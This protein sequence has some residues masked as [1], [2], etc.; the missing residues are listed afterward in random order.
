MC[1]IKLYYSSMS[2]SIPSGMRG[3][4]QFYTVDGKLVKFIWPQPHRSP[5]LFTFMNEIK[6]LRF[7]DHVEELLDVIEDDT[8]HALG[9]AVSSIPGQPMAFL[10]NRRYLGTNKKPLSQLLQIL[11]SLCDIVADLHSNDIFIGNL[12]ERLLSFTEDCKVYIV[13]PDE[14]LWM[15]LP[16]AYPS[17]VYCPDASMS[18]RHRDAYALAVLTSRVLFDLHPIIHGVVEGNPS[19]RDRYLSGVPFLGEGATSMPKPSRPLS[20]VPKVLIDTLRRACSPHTPLEDLKDFPR[21]LG[22]VL[23][24]TLD[25]LTHCPI[26]GDDYFRP[27]GST[28]GCPMC[29]EE[30]H[31][32][33]IPMGMDPLPY[34][35]EFSGNE[36]DV[37][38]DLDTYATKSGEIRSIS[39][40]FKVPI[41]K[42]T[43]QY[44]IPGVEHLY[45]NVVVTLYPR[46]MVVEAGSRRF[47]VPRAWGSTVV[48]DNGGIVYHGQRPYGNLSELEDGTSPGA[49]LRIN[50]H[51]LT[52]ASRENGGPNE[53]RFS[54]RVMI[55]QN[56][57]VLT[58]YQGSSHEYSALA[59]SFTGEALQLVLAN[60]YRSAILPRRREGV[61]AIVM[62]PRMIFD[63]LQ[64]SWTFI[65]RS[66]DGRMTYARMRYSAYG[67]YDTRITL[68][69]LDCP[70]HIENVCCYNDTLFIPQDGYII[71]QS[72]VDTA[73]RKEMWC[74]PID[75]RT[76]LVYDK[77]GLHAIRGKDILLLDVPK[78]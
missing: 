62:D 56:E 27:A 1:A 78:V 49:A 61:N 15:G 22:N 41:V 76:R 63:T 65:G 18:M 67:I 32:H 23:S 64:R 11:I 53:G 55:D 48:F 54:P 74:P 47:A 37:I 71:L 31:G 50:I 73:V 52:S 28:R 60:P 70:C 68:Q 6:Q 38:L 25:R 24:Y 7:P 58:L 39:T 77:N 40:D 2:G 14:W 3:H 69:A 26:H 13:G 30:L 72:L 4:S 59:A 8:D 33:E 42:G 66:L 5:G 45:P 16:F 29:E 19:H 44:L 36:V 12:S 34:S 17:Y 46:S 10:W 75:A 43:I 51:K 20:S 35:V 57:D 9:M 21:Q